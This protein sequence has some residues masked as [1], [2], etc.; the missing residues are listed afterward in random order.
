MTKLTY[1][2]FMKHAGKITKQKRLESRPALKN[3]NHKDGNVV[4]TDSHRLY[5]AYD[6]YTGENTLINPNTGERSVEFNYPETSRLIPLEDDAEHIIKIPDADLL[7]KALK[8]L[9]AA[10][11]AN[12]CGKVG[13]CKVRIANGEATL[14]TDDISKSNVKF[15]STFDVENNS[16]NECE[17]YF[18]IKYLLEAS[19][20]FKDDK[21]GSLEVRTYGRNRPITIS[22]E[23]GLALLLPIRRE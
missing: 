18:D 19:Q 3:V 21:V 12:E 11:K 5:V 9:D 15:E 2:N 16:T 4:V 13:I 8:A 7:F 10:D 23:N 20:M 22:C 14:M 1:L 6:V 17:L